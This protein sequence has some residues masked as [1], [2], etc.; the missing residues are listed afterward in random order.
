MDLNFNCFVFVCVDIARERF[1]ARQVAQELD[2]VAI[3]D[4]VQGITV[5]KNRKQVC[6]DDIMLIC[7]ANKTFLPFVRRFG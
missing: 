2:R 3:H 7:V 1:R 5:Q 4:E 6:V